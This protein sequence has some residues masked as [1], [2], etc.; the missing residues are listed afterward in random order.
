MSCICSLS[1]TEPGASWYFLGVESNLTSCL[2]NACT[3]GSY[4]A[5]VAQLSH[6]QHNY[7]DIVLYSCLI[8]MYLPC[9]LGVIY[10]NTSLITGR[11]HW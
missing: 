3:F 2:S 4:I 6:F 7:G 11:N 1:E 10:G 5:L 9:F 8:R